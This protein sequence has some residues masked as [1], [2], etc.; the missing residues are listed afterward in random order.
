EAGEAGEAEGIEGL[1][2]E[3]E[4][5]EAVEATETASQEEAEAAEA[6]EPEDAAEAEAAEPAQTELEAAPEADEVDAELTEETDAVE[7]AQPEED[8][9]ESAEPEPAVE[10][11]VEPA[12]EAEEAGSEPEPEP[13]PAADEPDISEELEELE[14]FISQGF[15]DDAAVAYMELVGRYPGHSALDPYTE[16][17]AA[18][19]ETPAEEAAAPVLLDDEA[20]LPDSSG[21]SGDSFEAPLFDFGENDEE[22]DF[23]SSIFDDDAPA[24]RKSKP[25][26]PPRARAELEGQADARDLFDLGTAYREMGLIDD[27]LTQF[28]MASKDPEWKAKSLVMMAS[29]HLHR[30]EI[31]LAIAD[32]E[33]AVAFAINDTEASEARYE[34]G[35]IFQVMGEHAKAIAAFEQVHV[36]YRDRDERLTALL[37]S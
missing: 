2:T 9:T 7:A 8:A 34:L 28:R 23:L 4:A 21:E 31:P 14:F 18:T 27:A 13:E 17:F 32:L 22:D 30:G 3:G 5:D 6:T 19:L 11:A 36:G 25:A 24:V 15:D 12:E 1:E 35:V 10:P 29:L 16:R 37:E 33:E 26:E 20:V